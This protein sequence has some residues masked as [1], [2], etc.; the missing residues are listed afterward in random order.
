MKI[1]FLDHQGVMYTRK[2]P[3]PGS[4]DNFD[5]KTIKELNSILELD[6]SIELVVSSDWKYWVD[7]LEMRDFYLRQG[8]KKAPIAYTPKTDTYN[9]PIYGQQRAKEINTWLS[10]NM[11][12]LHVT[13]WVAIDDIDMRDHLDHFVW[14]HQ[15]QEGITQSG[16]KEALLEHLGLQACNA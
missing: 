15:I 7:L 10:D 1:I 14:I 5:A 8:L 3:N 16:A 11:H 9:W 4:L 13:H 12:S 6:S 2:H